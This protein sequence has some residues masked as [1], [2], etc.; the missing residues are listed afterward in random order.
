MSLQLVSTFIGK[1]EKTPKT[2]LIDF[3]RPMY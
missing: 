2:N 1:Y 3:N